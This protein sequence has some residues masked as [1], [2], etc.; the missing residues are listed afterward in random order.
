MERKG[1]I[2]TGLRPLHQVL[3][4]GSYLEGSPKAGIAGSCCPVSS[5][6][7]AVLDTGEGWGLQICHHATGLAVSEL[8]QHVSL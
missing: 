6:L 2:L 4:Q 5:L 8:P 1:E 7:E 3:L